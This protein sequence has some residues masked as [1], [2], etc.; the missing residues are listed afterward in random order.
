MQRY[1][2]FLYDKKKYTISEGNRFSGETSKPHQHHHLVVLRHWKDEK[3]TE[4]NVTDICLKTDVEGVEVID[5]TI[6]A[7]GDNT[8]VGAIVTVEMGA[9]GGKNAHSS[10]DVGVCLT[11]IVG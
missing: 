9:T 3:E 2:F 1:T 7:A 6:T 5:Q 8:G 10:V 4:E 11:S